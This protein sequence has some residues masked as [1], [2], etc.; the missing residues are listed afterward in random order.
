MK[1]IFSRKGIDSG[2]GLRGYPLRWSPIL[3]D[4]RLVSLPIY[5]PGESTCY[6]E[7]MLD[8][9]RTYLD[10]IRELGY[11]YPERTPCHRDPDIYKHVM[12]RPR[13]WRPLSGHNVP[14]TT[15]LSN[16][17]VGP[18][19]LF[20]YFGLFRP[21]CCDGYGRLHFEG[22]E[23]HTI[24]GYLQIER[25]LPVGP[26]TE[27][28]PYMESHPHA[29]PRA[30]CDKGNVIFVS[31]KTAT[32]DPKLPGAGVFRYHPDLMLSAGGGFPKRVWRLP[33]CFQAAAISY[34][35]QASWRGELFHSACRGQEF[36]VQDHSG[37][38][39][40]AERLIAR[41]PRLVG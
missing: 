34:H 20:L 30:R 9:E 5:R 27:L 3:P 39:T 10:L 18:G 8:R 38:E 4:D 41:C 24:F 21:T 11:Q 7:L 31:R 33:K 32:W 12:A 15:H 2:S 16:Q 22:D 40:W 35:R 37:V 26:R 13:G 1:I 6:D 14:D 17:G 19:D 29:A 25:I 23:Q 36:V 28:P